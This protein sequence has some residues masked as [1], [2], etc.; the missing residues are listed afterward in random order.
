MIHK[1]I[2]IFSPSIFKEQHKKKYIYIKKNSIKKSHHTK[3]LI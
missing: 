2:R 3:T 1:I